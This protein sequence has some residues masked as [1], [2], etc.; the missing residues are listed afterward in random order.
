[1]SLS[2]VQLRTQIP[3]SSRVILAVDRTQWD[4]NNLLM[5]AAIW[6]KR[7]F[8]VYWQFL[9]AAVI[10]PNKLQLFVPS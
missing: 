6:K 1:L 9:D 4:S 5:V 10:N 7:A 3:Y 2:K 8:P